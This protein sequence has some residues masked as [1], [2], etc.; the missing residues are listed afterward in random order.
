MEA[1]NL[2]PLAHEGLSLVV[3]TEHLKLKVLDSSY[4]ECNKV[5][6]SRFRKLKVLDSSYHG[7][8]RVI[9]SRFR[10]HTCCNQFSSQTLA[11]PLK[12]AELN[13]ALCSTSHDLSDTQGH[14]LY[15]QIVIVSRDCS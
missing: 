3:N 2:G 11:T 10:N 1:R 9:T 12:L 8:T 14:F 15:C 5:I 4:Q 13:L 6:T 7:C